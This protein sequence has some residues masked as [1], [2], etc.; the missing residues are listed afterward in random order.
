MMVYEETTGS[1]FPATC[2]FQ[3]VDQP[4]VQRENLGK[5]MCDLYGGAGIFGGGKAGPANASDRIEK[6]QAQVGDAMH[7][8]SMTRKRSPIMSRRCESIRSFTRD[9]FRTKRAELACV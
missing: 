2:S 6:L 3:P 8:G 9:L 7:G 5:E 1:L 4:A